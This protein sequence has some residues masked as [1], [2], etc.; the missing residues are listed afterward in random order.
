MTGDQLVLIL[1]I[2][3]FAAVIKSIAGFGYPLLLL[4]VLAQFIDV[5]DAVL[6]IAPSNLFLNVGMAWKLRSHHGEA[7]TLNVFTLTGLIGAI[8]GALILPLLPAQ[9]F[10]LILLIV[11]VA[12]LAHRL[13][14]FKVTLS[15]SNAKRWAPVVGGV[16]GVFQGGASVSGPIVT[17]WFLSVGV[18]RDTFVYSIAAFFTLTGIMQIIVATFDQL[19]TRDIVT[20]GLLLVPLSVISIPIGAL[21]RDRISAAAFERVVVGLLAV[22]ALT[23]LARLLS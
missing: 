4:P 22:S 23:L 18:E 12:F 11:L 14:G 10:R 3:G 9:L 17:P 8:V 21:I 5:V 16:A 19:F 1:V 2:G 13:S 6:I 15:E 7:T 20:I